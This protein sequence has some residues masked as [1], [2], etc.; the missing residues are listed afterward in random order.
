MEAWPAPG[1]G[2][3]RIAFDPSAARPE[4]VRRAITEPFFDAQL[5]LWQ[6]SPFE[7]AEN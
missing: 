6:H 2:R 3:A 5:G 4:D 7:L 1:G